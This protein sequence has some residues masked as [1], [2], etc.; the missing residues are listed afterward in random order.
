M[1]K[2]KCDVYTE[3]IHA[4]HG[5]YVEYMM[6][7]SDYN[8]DGPYP[9]SYPTRVI[10]P[11]INKY[12]TSSDEGDYSDSDSLMEIETDSELGYEPAPG[13]GINLATGG[14]HFDDEFEDSTGD[15]MR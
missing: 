15:T 13:I 2:D 10:V 11:H 6:A 9:Y 3:H 12:E 5:G 1:L 4:Q 8:E 14:G 7:D